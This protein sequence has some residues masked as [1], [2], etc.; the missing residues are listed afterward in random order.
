MVRENR[1]TNRFREIGEVQKNWGWFFALGLLLIFLGLAVISS[2]FVATLFSIILL[3]IFLMAAGV[4]Q[5]VQSFLARKWSGFFLSL[6]LGL[7]YIIAGFFCVA[8]PEITVLTLTLWIAAFCFLVGLFRM[9]SSVILRFDEWGWVFLNG[10][11][12]FL[13]GAMIYANWPI[14]GLW[15]IGVFV[16]VDM[17][18]SGLSWIILSLTAKDAQIE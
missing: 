8:R 16:G 11:I 2:A 18:F 6:F 7:L 12:T 9:L 5:I 15:V 14:S 17:I 1:L 10:L 3:G 4:V 13:L